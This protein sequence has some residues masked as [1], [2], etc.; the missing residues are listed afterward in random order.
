VGN[1]EL[2]YGLQTEEQPNCI[3]V[4]L[5]SVAP[6]YRAASLVAAVW[7]I[8]LTSRDELHLLPTFC[9]FPAFG[10]R[11]SI[12]AKTAPT[13]TFPPGPKGLPL[14][15]NL[16][17]L[18]KD[19][20]WLTY[21]KWGQELGKQK[22]GLPVATLYQSIDAQGLISFTWSFSGRIWLS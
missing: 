20:E 5:N 13:A 15:G 21:E 12:G 4:N 9:C 8:T 11:I 18:P 7:H 3:Q 19:Y 6:L 22:N 10:D 17:D 14:I 2:L 16:R 1:P